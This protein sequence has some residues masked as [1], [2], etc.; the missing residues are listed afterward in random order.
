LS[1]KPDE[2]KSGESPNAIVEEKTRRGRKAGAIYFPRDSLTR[3]LRVPQV[4]WEKNAGNPYPLIDIASKLGNSPT[5]GTFRELVRSAQRYGLINESYTQ[6]LTKTISLTK[7]GNSI[8]APT[9]DENVNA[10]KRQALETPDLFRKVYS[11]LQG[12]IIPPADSIKNMLIRN[13][14]LDK[15]DAEVCHEILRQNIADLGISEDIQGKVYLR[16]DRLGI[17]TKTPAEE[18]GEEQK[19]SET[20][21]VAPLTQQPSMTEENVVKI[22]RVFISHSKNKKVLGNIEDMLKFGGFDYRVAEEKETLSMPLSDKVFGLMRE[23]NCAIINLSADQEKKEGD[24]Y[25]LNEN[26]LIEIGAAFLYYDRRVLLVI[27]KKLENK[28]PS[29]LKGITAIFYEGQEL[30]LTD[31]MKLM[32]TLGEFR[33]KL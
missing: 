20:L 33:A 27:D 26:V 31:G 17:G 7:L 11:S 16:L 3:A 28:L 13:Y 6:D 30:T 23:C 19:P 22:P 14:H 18:E 24:E 10:L 2:S 21:E 1:P 12:K 15:F 9:P 25:G 5:S 4:I 8:V 29:I 32:K